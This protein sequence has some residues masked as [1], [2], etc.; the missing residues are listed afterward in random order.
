MNI[1]E[2]DRTTTDK[3]YQ[4]MLRFEVFTVVTMKNVVFWVV[5]PCRS[6]VNQRFGGT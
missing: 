2:E 4:N 5:A 1:A 6:C 3:P